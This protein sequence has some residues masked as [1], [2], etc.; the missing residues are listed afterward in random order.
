MH[1]RVILRA[2]INDSI[3]GIRCGGMISMRINEDR[4]VEA[5]CDE[6]IAWVEREKRDV[7]GSGPARFEACSHMYERSPIVRLGKTRVDN[8][9]HGIST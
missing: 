3:E 2:F 8:F 1:S 6:R 9:R 5:R 4:T 7:D